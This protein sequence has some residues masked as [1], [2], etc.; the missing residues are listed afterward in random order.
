MSILLPYFTARVIG[1]SLL[2]LGYLVVR[3]LG[4]GIGPKSW[5]R[6]FRGE[7]GDNKPKLAISKLK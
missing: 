3:L 1:L 2:V 5:K 6:W 7:T 4:F